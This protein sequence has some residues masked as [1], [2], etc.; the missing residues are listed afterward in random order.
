MEQDKAEAKICGILSWLARHVIRGR[1][2]ALPTFEPH[3]DHR[4]DQVR[5]TITAQYFDGRMLPWVL[6]SIHCL[7]SVA[8]V[9][10]HR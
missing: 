3:R 6:A 9:V 2:K 10:K 4:Q 5:K 7:C 8:I 1:I